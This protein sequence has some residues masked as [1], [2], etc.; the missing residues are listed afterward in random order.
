[1]KILVALVLSLSCTFVYADENT[2]RIKELKTEISQREGAIAQLK[3]EG[4]A[5]G[6]FEMTV[7]RLKQE[8]ERRELT[9]EMLN[10]GT[11][12]TNDS[13]LD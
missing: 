9:E 1:M 12:G 3:S 4:K 8:L 7:F 2:D 6:R 5:T 13:K 11:K 10:T